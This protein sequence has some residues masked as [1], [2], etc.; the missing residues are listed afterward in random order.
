MIQAY[1]LYRIILFFDLRVFNYTAMKY[2]CIF[3]LCLF[4][5]P[6]KS[7]SQVPVYVP[8]VKQYAMNTFG[9]K[10]VLRELY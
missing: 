5:Q 9:G 8:A 4:F 2:L 1:K 3:L 7:V 6:L 10:N